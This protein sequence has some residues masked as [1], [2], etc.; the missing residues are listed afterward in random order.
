V[1]NPPAGGHWA[2][3]LQNALLR[4]CARDD[5]RAV[6]IPKDEIMGADWHSVADNTLENHSKAPHLRDVIERFGVMQ[7]RLMPGGYLKPSI[8][9][10]IRT[11]TNKNR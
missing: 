8:G 2:S 10:R 7:H 1:R 6:I 9:A 4:L 3:L 11:V 5:D